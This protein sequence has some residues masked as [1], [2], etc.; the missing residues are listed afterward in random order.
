MKSISVYFHAQHLYYLPQFLPVYELCKQNNI[1][2]KL[3]FTLQFSDKKLLESII[4]KEKLDH[5][6]TDNNE[7]ALELYNRDKP[8]WI[9][10]GNTFDRIKEISNNIKTALIYHGIG[11]KEC[12]YDK[13][14]TEMDIRFIEGD[15]RYQQIKK[16]FPDAN[17]VTTGFSKLDPIINNTF[18][19]KAL[20]K[21]Y[22]L[23][24]E[25]KT[26]LYAPTFYPSSIEKMDKDWP[27]VFSE[28]NIIIKPHQF[29]LTKKNYKRHVKLFKHWESF[30]NVYLASQV[31]YS[32][33]P[34]MAVSDILVSEASSAMFEFA[35][36]G[37]PV[38]WCDFVKLRWNYRGI[39]RY[40]YN[41]RMDKDILRYSDIAAHV[42][43]YKELN[44][45]LKQELN[46]LENH[47]EKRQQYSHELLG[48]IDGQASN[49]IYKYITKYISKT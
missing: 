24:P 49:L 45:T 3:I 46:H 26:I 1:N 5:L 18:D 32:L 12:Y 23:D 20:Q 4:I 43:K 19:I 2:T 28:F 6:F 47:K 35:G 14:L 42:I 33:V 40:R 30:N 17:L 16:R 41:Q 31:D 9:I 21:Q 13:E 48:D 34:F 22:G 8:S 10:F 39:F 44:K 11:V 37:K 25:K 29:S 27:S 7:T 36:L 38:I 15:Y